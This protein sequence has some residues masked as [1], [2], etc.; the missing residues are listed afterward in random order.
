MGLKSWFK[1][2]VKEAAA[3]EVERV[4][5]DLQKGKPMDPKL[6]ATLE[7]MLFLVLAAFCGGLA[8]ALA[9]GSLT[10]AEVLTA[11]GAAVAVIPAYLRK[12]AVESK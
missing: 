2:R 12:P 6:K 1:K 9:D 4:A 5:A 3:E 7:V 8:N 10:K 11:L